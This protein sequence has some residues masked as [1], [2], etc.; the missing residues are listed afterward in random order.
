[1]KM[2]PTIDVARLTAAGI[3]ALRRGDSRSARELFDRVVAAGKADASTFV[4]IAFACRA[5]GDARAAMA[6]LERALALEPRNVQAL[7]VKGDFFA[8]AGDAR[9]AA[10]FYRAG[11]NAVARRED[12][13]PEFRKE[14]ERAEAAVARYEREFQTYLDGS[15]AARGLRE[16][17]ASRR[18][19]QSLDL[20]Y[21]RKEIYLQRPRYYYFPE[22]PLV[23]FFD[24]RAF[25]W[26]EELEQHTPA[27]RAEAEAVMRD[28][29]AFK[30][31]VEA[32]PNRPRNDQQGM[33]D[34]PDWS[35]FY[36]WK[37]GELL[38]QNAARC[39]ATT[40][41]MERIPLV[42]TQNRS[43]SVLFSLLRPGAHIPPHNGMINTRLICHLPLVVP[44]G[45]EFRVG[46][47]TREW[48]E[49]R[50]WAFDDSI[51]H[52]AWNRSREP[53]VILIFEV[54]RP[55]L[56]EAERGLVNAMFEAIDAHTGDKPAWE[57]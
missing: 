45:C 33:L 17:E 8:A 56:T 19:R 15:L 43:P 48:V 26:M 41:A 31:Y 35:A 47:E 36:V 50:A 46:N 28:A 40:R 30:P 42:R 11:V 12:L 25:P 21:G 18:F 32:E 13:P 1:M 20:L 54:W 16:D 7:V 39:P 27:I 24:R 37:R 44:P 51:E 49:G 4:G 9:A 55:E 34:N 52:E 22:L 23:Q 53:R 57:I 2:N 5:A 10:A 14:V 6:A 38:A 3:D 29:T